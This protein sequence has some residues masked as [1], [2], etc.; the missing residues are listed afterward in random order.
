MAKLQRWVNS[1]GN[2]LCYREIQLQPSQL[3]LH[4]LLN[5]K[6]LHLLQSRAQKS[7]MSVQMMKM[8]QRWKANRKKTNL[9]QMKDPIRWTKVLRQGCPERST[10]CMEIGQ[11]AASVEIKPS[12][13]W[14]AV[15][16]SKGA[17]INRV[18]A[19]TT[20]QG[21]R[22]LPSIGKGAFLRL[23]SMRIT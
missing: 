1:L 10:L 3:L 18:H 2:T 23:H 21:H 5:P 12:R 14:G 20:A 4:L 8:H 15:H 16:Q 11:H 9:F 17:L 19:K 7:Y 6:V 22:V 13:Y